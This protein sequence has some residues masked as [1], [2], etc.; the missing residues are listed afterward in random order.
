MSV[1]IDSILTEWRYRLPSGYP[2]TAQDFEVLRN[3]ILEMTDID[4]TEAERIVR[5]SMGLT[6]APDDFDTDQPEDETL[7]FYD[8]ISF[9]QFILNHYAAKT[10][11]INGLVGLYEKIKTDS[12]LL[13]L[14]RSFT[15]EVPIQPG[16]W[17]ITGKYLR[18]YNAVE[19]NIKIKNGHASELWFALVF[20]GMVK[21]SV[22]NIP[23]LE[24]ENDLKSD[25]VTKDGQR[26]SLKAYGD[27]TFDFGMLP[28]ELVF[29]L[30]SFL[31]LSELITGNE[32]K[33]VS[34]SIPDINE[35]VL[36]LLNDEQIQDEIKQLLELD[37]PFVTIQ[38]L[39]NKIRN[40]MYKLDVDSPDYLESVTKKFCME[41][42]RF[43][44]NHISENIDWWA[45]I[46][47]TNKT[48]NLIPS[49][50]IV[51]SLKHTEQNGD[52]YL[53]TNIA[54]FHQGHLTVK[55]SHLGVT[56]AKYK[57]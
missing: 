54:S 11:S 7:D 18:L 31:A 42:D 26:F 3:V 5:R 44:D 29:Y 14:I 48:L 28:A 40:I 36:R 2:Q 9:E 19:T 22:K 32:M 53:S 24:I 35:N 57:D 4:L 37:S 13:S 20:K 1:N 34:L 49:K 10:Q 51:D 47:T 30:R 39:Q 21:G 43:I 8:A 38:N 52:Y 16:P 17:R 55:T 23:E 12:E 33:T 50:T 25:V 6:E 56:T 27:T 15:S 46:I 45:L 41:I